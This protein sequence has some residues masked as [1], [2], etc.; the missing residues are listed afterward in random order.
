MIVD[1]SSPAFRSSSAEYEQSPE[2]WKP[3][4]S[5]IRQNVPLHAGPANPDPPDSLEM[6]APGPHPPT[7]A[8][9]A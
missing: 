2:L 8:Q 6:P 5:L 7:P 4:G 3:Y 1:N 9:P